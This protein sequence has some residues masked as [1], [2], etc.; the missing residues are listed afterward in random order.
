MRQGKVHRTTRETKITAEINLDGSGQAQIH[1]GIGFFDH[2]LESFTKH[3]GF[4]LR[5][6][7]KGDLHVDM[8][9]TVEDVGICIGAALKEAL[10]AHTGIRRYG[11]AYIP[12][13]ETLSRAAIDLAN[14]PYLIWRVTLA[15]PKLG[16][17]DTELFKEFFQAF[18]MHSGACLHMEN[19]YGENTH[20]IVESCY[21]ALARATRMAVEID[22]KAAGSAPS[23]KGV[24]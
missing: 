15:R 20:H 16:E 5:V 24:L 3:G 18:A 1:T 19:L 9:H 2:M 6:E 14:R 22:P 4:D 23:T 17:M 12:M 8:H 21:K 7:A 13:D 11:H 10:G